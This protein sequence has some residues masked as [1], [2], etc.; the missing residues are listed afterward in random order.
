MMRMIVFRR[1]FASCTRTRDRPTRP[2]QPRLYR[3]KRAPAC[4]LRNH[5][6]D[7]AEPWHGAAESEIRHVHSAVRSQRHRR[8]EGES[9]RDDGLLSVRIDPDDPSCIELA[10]SWKTRRGHRLKDVQAI[11]RVKREAEYG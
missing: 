2:P 8:R 9:G 1:E 7:L 3:L 5:P 6:V 10:G 4:R 11:A